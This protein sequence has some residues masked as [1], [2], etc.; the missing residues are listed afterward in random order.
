MAENVAQGNEALILEKVQ[1][2]ENTE[3][4]HAEDVLNQITLGKHDTMNCYLLK[5]TL[6][7]E[8]LPEFDMPISRNNLAF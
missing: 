2:G 7:N 6:F 8:N 5:S 4:K 1:Q 3:E